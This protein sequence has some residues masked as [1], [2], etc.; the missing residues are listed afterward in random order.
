MCRSSATFSGPRFASPKFDA[1][2]PSYIRGGGFGIVCSLEGE[3]L[4]F[5]AGKVG[6]ALDK[7][8]SCHVRDVHL[9]ASTTKAQ[10]GDGWEAHIIVYGQACNQYSI[11]DF[12]GKEGVFLQHPE[13]HDESVPYQ[14]PQYLIRPGE[15]L[16]IPDDYSVSTDAPEIR[17][18]MSK[19]V[20]S[21]LEVF[22][23]AG[24]L[25]EFPP[26]NINTRLTTILKP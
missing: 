21:V 10:G 19:L 18:P 16:K 8:L 22:K 15:V 14:N 26:V 20:D 6:L 13:H 7:L 1:V 9:N 23:G 25:E 12:L 4:G 2:Q 3:F 17:I 11:G 24:T 5:L